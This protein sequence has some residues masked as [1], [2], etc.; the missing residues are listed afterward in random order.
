ML[1]VTGGRE[2]TV[3]ELDDLFASAGFAPGAIIET[4]GRV[5]IVETEAIEHPPSPQ[6]P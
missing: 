2:R 3:A 4:A 6:R 5:R 1:A